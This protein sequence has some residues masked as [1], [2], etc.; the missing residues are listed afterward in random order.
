[1]KDKLKLSEVSLQII[2][3]NNV[4]KIHLLVN[5]SDTVNI[6][7]DNFNV[8]NFKCGKLFSVKLAYKVK[9]Y[10]H[11]SKLSPKASQEVQTLA[12]MK[13]YINI[14]KKYILMNA[15]FTL[16]SWCRLHK[17]SWNYLS[18]KTFSYS[19]TIPLPFTK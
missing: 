15:S 2:F 3:T 12:R 8:S 6:R 13:L 11:I 4:E 14:S 19:L 16:S 17:F 7:R 5:I 18:V 9:C 1:M 10:D